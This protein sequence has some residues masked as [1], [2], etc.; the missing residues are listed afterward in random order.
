MEDYRSAV[1]IY[2]F[3]SKLNDLWNEFPML[4]FG[5]LLYNIYPADPFYVEDDVM[6]KK[7][8]EFREKFGKDD[9]GN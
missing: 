7:I 5:Q 9:D 1:D 2:F 3:L 6:L 8:E 4:R